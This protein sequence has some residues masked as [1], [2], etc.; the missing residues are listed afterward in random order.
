MNDMWPVFSDEETEAVSKVLR[1][2]KVN[3]WTGNEC[4]YFEEEFASYLGVQHAVSVSNGTVAIELILRAYGI[5]V[6]DE[7]IVPSRTFIGTASA[8]AACGA[9][10]IVAD[11]EPASQG[12]CLD[13]I[14]SCCTER[15]KAVIVVHLGGWPVDI[16][17]IKEWTNQ[18]NIAVFEDCAQAHGASYRE[19]KVGTIGEAAA[20]S[21]CQD[22]IMSTAGEGG[23]V[24]TN[25]SEIW[26]G[27]W[28]YKDHGKNYDLVQEKNPN[29]SFRYLHDTFGT[30]ARMT[31][32]QAAIGRIQL[33]K[34]DRWVARRQQ[35]AKV[36]IDGC[37]DLNVIHFPIPESHIHNSYYRLYGFLQEE[38]LDTNW[39]RDKIIT[40]L[41]ESNIGVGSGSGEINKE[42]ALRDWAGNSTCTIA[43][44]CCR[45][46]LAFCVHP[47][48][49]DKTLVAIVRKIREVLKLV[50]KCS[51]DKRSAA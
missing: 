27:V 11:I 21:F 15:T 48:I 24:V 44:S 47:T 9:K 33:K 49:Q 4:R 13:S 20:F 34:L 3:Y 5:G 28:E 18:K 23:M 51:T 46:S 40:L 43:E 1:S 8:V 29:K 19:Q 41:N 37:S 12:I 35:I 6:G 16:S 39:S 22:K 42:K 32:C 7:V 50:T 30:N 10:P 36:I 14:K 45:T 25:N 31:E 2:G 38:H 17:G 26:R